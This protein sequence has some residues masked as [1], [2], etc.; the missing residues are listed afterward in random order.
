MRMA[1]LDQPFAAD[2][3]GGFQLL[4]RFTLAGSNQPQLSSGKAWYS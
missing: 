4:H 1:S 3:V 2:S